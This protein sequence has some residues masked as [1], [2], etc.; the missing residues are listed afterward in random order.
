MLILVNLTN[1][2]P[3]QKTYTS[4]GSKKENKVPIFLQKFQILS[5]FCLCIFIWIEKKQSF[6]FKGSFRIT[7]LSRTTKRWTK[8]FFKIYIWN[9][10]WSQRTTKAVRTCGTK[11]KEK[12]ETKKVIPKLRA[13]FPP[14]KMPVLKTINN[15]YE[16]EKVSTIFFTLTGLGE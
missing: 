7:I 12:K 14:G 16:A 4:Q 13:L 1:P 11:I 3:F 6:H 10:R 15:K 2:C 9:K 8:C 5:V